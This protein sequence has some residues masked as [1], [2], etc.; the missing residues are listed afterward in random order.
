MV[1]IFLFRHAHVD[2]APPAQNI[3]D[4]PLT[5]LGHRM[6]A[7][8][9]ERCDE[10][11]LQHLFV[12]TMLRAQQTADAISQRFPD[13][14]RLDMPE[15]EETS[16][17]DLEGYP[18]A[19]PPED[20]NAWEIERWIYARIPRKERVEAGWEKVRHITDEL[21]LERV[22]IISHFGPLNVLL[23]LFLSE[24]ADCLRDCWFDLD[25]TSTSCLRYQSE[26]GW[27]ERWIRWINDARHIEDLR[28]VS[29][30]AGTLD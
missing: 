11:D 13:I 22:A 16:I 9:A 7:R 18:G 14:P 30:P 26:G 23:R 24:D 8:L 28:H 1:D 20:L 10:W 19:L 4:T 2:Y 12:S 3:A 15:F 27:G 25:W 5:L 6:S 17:K 29:T 21:G